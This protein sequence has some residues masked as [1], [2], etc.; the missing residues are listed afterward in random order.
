MDLADVSG[1]TVDGVHVASTGGVWMALVHGFAGMRDHGG[2]M[3]F[4][5]RLP[6]HWGRLAFSLRFQDR[7][8]R[9]VLET[10]LLELTV[11]EGDA[12]EVDVRGASHL[13]GP[14]VACRVAV[15]AR[16]LQQRDRSGSP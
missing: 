4:D 12:L 16:W 10:D 6:S 11:L 9:V 7:V 14:G 2:R 1:N 15:E 8:L 5:P 3:S 13:L